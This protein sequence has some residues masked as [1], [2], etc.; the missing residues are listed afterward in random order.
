MRKK[1]IKPRYSDKTW[2]SFRSL[3]IPTPDADDLCLYRDCYCVGEDKGSYSPGRGYTSYH[4]EPLPICMA[5]MCHGCPSGPIVDNRVSRP[6]PP[7]DKVMDGVERRIKGA[8]T[9][10]QRRKA[11]GHMSRVLRLMKVYL[12]R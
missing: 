11:E 8:K 7:W 4:A 6:I 9:A 2:E 3:E 1:K 5:R 12:F 10:A